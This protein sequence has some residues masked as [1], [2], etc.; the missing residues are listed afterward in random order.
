MNQKNIFEHDMSYFYLQS[1]SLLHLQVCK[2]NVKI[3]FY[4]QRDYFRNDRPLSFFFIKLLKFPVNSN[5]TIK[6]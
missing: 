2:I 5:F 1:C 3:H 6:H 4:T